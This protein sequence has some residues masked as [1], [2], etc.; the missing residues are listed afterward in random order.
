MAP[1]MAHSSTESQS[2]PAIQLIRP[3]MKVWVQKHAITINTNQVFDFSAPLLYVK[4]KR[5]R[6]A[7]PLD[8][9]PNYRRRITLT[10]TLSLL[11]LDQWYAND[12]YM[13][14]NSPGFGALFF[15][16]AFYVC[17]LQWYPLVCV[18]GPT[19]LAWCSP[20]FYLHF[21]CLAVQVWALI[22]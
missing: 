20:S 11:V 1:S 17:A 16:M 6:V 4:R 8:W 2:T 10:E 19:S 12:L 22:V 5:S 9:T 21:S 14:Q 3:T 7:D 15:N 18:G 13:V